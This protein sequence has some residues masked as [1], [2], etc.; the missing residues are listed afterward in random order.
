MTLM[1][2]LQ[3]AMPQLTRNEISCLCQVWHTTACKLP[4]NS[5][6]CQAHFAL[7][8]ALRW[9]LCPALTDTAT[10]KFGTMEEDTVVG[11]AQ[12]HTATVAIAYFLVC[13][14]CLVVT[15]LL[16]WPL[17]VFLCYAEEW[18]WPW[19]A[20]LEDWFGQCLAIEVSVRTRTGAASQSLQ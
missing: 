3:E 7:Q 16:L 14:T 8:H 2:V 9:F 10:G 12:G 5:S 19:G 4:G 6:K 18:H 17:F 20:R 15:C 11:S 13:K 1:R